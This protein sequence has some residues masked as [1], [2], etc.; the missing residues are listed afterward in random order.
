MEADRV[1]V[2]DHGTQNDRLWL[3][4]GS[5]L[6]NVH[7]SFAFSFLTFFSFNTDDN[8]WDSF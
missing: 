8:L 1:K 2:T 7:N 4:R 3:S 6:A 5:V